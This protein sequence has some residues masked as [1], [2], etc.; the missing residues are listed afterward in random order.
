MS[1][2]LTI[3]RLAQDSVLLPP[4]TKAT[5]SFYLPIHSWMLITVGYLSNTE[6]QDRVL[7]Q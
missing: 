6:T 5:I 2:L 3:G 1:D 4:V 7:R